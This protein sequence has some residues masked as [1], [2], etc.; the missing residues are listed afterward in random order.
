M[1]TP[2]STGTTCIAES[3]APSFTAQPARRLAKSVADHK[4]PPAYPVRA[5]ILPGGEMAAILLAPTLKLP[6]A[7]LRLSD[8][9][10]DPRI[11]GEH[12]G[13]L[14]HLVDVGRGALA[15]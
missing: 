7:R 6:Q 5:S 9:F 8:L 13:V 1:R 3:C 2:E 4:Q 10:P 14:F 11:G 12:P 15:Q